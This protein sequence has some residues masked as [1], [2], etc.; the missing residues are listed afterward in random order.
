M[1]EIIL[2]PTKT[3]LEKLHP[4]PLVILPVLILSHKPSNSLYVR[5]FK[6]LI[7]R[8]IYAHTRLA[9]A[10]A[11]ITTAR[12]MA[13]GI[14]TSVISVKARSAEPKGELDANNS[15]FFFR[16]A[17]GRRCWDK[18]IHLVLQAKNPLPVCIPSDSQY[19]E[20]R[21]ETLRQVS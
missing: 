6:P 12:L 15:N 19:A 21:E 10:V 16:S 13:V 14:A 18:V 9:E 2:H 3:W 1:R 20:K 5:V 17:R 7:A 4:Q 8:N 11:T